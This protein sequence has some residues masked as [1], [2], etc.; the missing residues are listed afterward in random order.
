MNQY[1]NNCPAENP[2]DQVRLLYTALARHPEKVLAGAKAGRMPA[3]WAM[4]MNG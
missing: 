2:L 1:D 3:H 4:P